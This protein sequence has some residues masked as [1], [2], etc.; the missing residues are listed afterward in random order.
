MSMLLTPAALTL[1]IT[2]FSEGAGTARSSRHSSISGPPMPIRATP[3]IVLGKAISFSNIL[4]T[5]TLGIPQDCQSER[6]AILLYSPQ[7]HRSHGQFNR[8][9]LSQTLDLAPLHRLSIRHD[10][11]RI[12]YYLLHYLLNHSSGAFCHFI[13]RLESLS[14]R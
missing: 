3:D 2:S 9:R 4:Q 13:L 7:L 1:T 14:P 11:T 6:E 12:H 10:T 8:C 5:D